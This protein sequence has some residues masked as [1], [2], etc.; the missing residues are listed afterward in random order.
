[1]HIKKMQS[2]RDQGNGGSLSYK[3]STLIAVKKSLE[4]AIIDQKKS[5]LNVEQFALQPLASP[6]LFVLNNYK[7]K[8]KL[9]AIKCQMFRIVSRD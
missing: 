6:S 2:L 8:T 7:F 3:F 5:K 4:A 1:M 9:R